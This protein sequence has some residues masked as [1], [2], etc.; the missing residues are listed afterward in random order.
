MHFP[1]NFRVFLCSLSREVNSLY[2]ICTV[3]T[4]TKS[5]WFSLFPF[6]KVGTCCISR[7]PDLRTKIWGQILGLYTRIY[8]TFHRHFFSF[9]V[10]ST[11]QCN[12]TSSF[13]CSILAKTRISN[14]TNRN[15]FRISNLLSSKQESKLF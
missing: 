5:C 2:S 8:G 12:S 11:Q 14:R 10:T 7:P 9:P 13:I 6:S 15:G 4:V 3:D 1:R